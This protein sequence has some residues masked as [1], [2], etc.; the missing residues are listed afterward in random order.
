MNYV[1]KY[2]LHA[3]LVGHK[4]VP[5]DTSEEWIEWIKSV[6]DEPQI[7]QWDRLCENQVSVSTVFNLGINMN[8]VGPPAWFATKV[9]GLTDPAARMLGTDL[10]DGE[11]RTATWNQAVGAHLAVLERTLSIISSSP[12]LPPDTHAY[13]IRC[14]RA[15]AEIA[16]MRCHC[17]VIARLN[18]QGSN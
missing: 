18:R 11:W 8:I 3:K 6:G 14:R 5:L 15:I 4:V 13:C 1:K 12:V 9:F 2:Q 17:E 7:V 16:G 10:T